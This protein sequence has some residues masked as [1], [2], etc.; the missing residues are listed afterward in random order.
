MSLK[1]FYLR[2]NKRQIIALQQHL[3][4]NLLNVQMVV[5]LLST[6][7]GSKFW[8]VK[9]WDESPWLFQVY[10]SK[11]DHYTM[12]HSISRICCGHNTPHHLSMVCKGKRSQR[13][14]CNKM[15]FKMQNKDEF[16]KKNVFPRG[17]DLGWL[18]DLP[19]L[20]APSNCFGYSDLFLLSCIQYRTDYWPPLFTWSLNCSCWTELLALLVNWTQTVFRFCYLHWAVRFSKT[21]AS[22][23]QLL[24]TA[25]T[26]S[27]P[28]CVY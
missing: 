1:A 9:N 15:H 17:S 21:S 25:C 2:Q 11:H 26:E 4:S 24:R 19:S 5:L 20:P 22:V 7:W 13:H 18:L 10:M 16:K 8:Y 28:L 12:K 14:S 3:F 23:L 27:V 6:R